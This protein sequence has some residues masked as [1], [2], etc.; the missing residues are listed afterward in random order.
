MR[1]D[2]AG[3][4]TLAFRQSPHDLSRWL[5]LDDPRHNIAMVEVGYDDV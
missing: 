3:L 5:H 4:R 2:L 1:T